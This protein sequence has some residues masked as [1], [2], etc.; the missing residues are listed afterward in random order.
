MGLDHSS[1]EEDLSN[2]PD[3]SLPG[4]HGQKCFPR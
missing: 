2:Q 4:G 1:K 3:L